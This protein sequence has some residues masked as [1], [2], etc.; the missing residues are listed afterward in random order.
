MREKGC[1]RGG[2]GRREGETRERSEREGE[3]RFNH[4]FLHAKTGS[5]PRTFSSNHAPPSTV[6]SSEN[7]PVTTKDD[8]HQYFIPAP[9]AAKRRPDGTR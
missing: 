1:E 5:L 2:G 6:S 9:R 8:S 7:I 3:E 4:P